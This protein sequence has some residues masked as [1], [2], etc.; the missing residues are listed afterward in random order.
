MERLEVVATGWRFKFHEKDIRGLNYLIVKDVSRYDGTTSD[1][2]FCIRFVYDANT[3]SAT[4]AMYPMIKSAITHY[5]VS[6]PFMC[7]AFENVSFEELIERLTDRISNSYAE[8][9]DETITL[10]WSKQEVIIE[11]PSKEFPNDL[12]FN[13]DS[14]TDKLES[15]CIHMDR[16][17]ETVACGYEVPVNV[18]YYDPAT[19]VE[20]NVK[21]YRVKFIG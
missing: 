21:C 8:D 1:L 9:E 10:Y 17:T 20:E 11:K 18:C 4:Y 13:F 7:R 6:K 14:N 3:K 15:M 12:L 5:M 16:I 19:A 2:R